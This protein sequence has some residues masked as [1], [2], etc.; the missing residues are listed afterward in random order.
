[1]SAAII[2]LASQVREKPCGIKIAFN[3]MGNVFF[4]CSVHSTEKELPPT[5]LSD[6]IKIPNREGNPLSDICKRR[7]TRALKKFLEEEDK[8]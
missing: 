1:M 5:I 7:I 6:G 8:A 3:Q 2:N 4:I